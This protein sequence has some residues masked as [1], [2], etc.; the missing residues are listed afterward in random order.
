MGIISGIKMLLGTPKVVSTVADTVKSGMG[1][2]D[3]WKYT[4]QEKATNA[5]K[6]ADVWL[7]IQKITANENSIKSVTRRILAWGIIANFLAIINIGVYLILRGET[8]K[9]TALKDFIVETNMG[10]MALSVVIFYFG[11]YGVQAI[12]NSKDK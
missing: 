3:N 2:L 1:M 9:V 12:R 6:F 8:K 10:W 11:Y 7:S 5:L 4:D